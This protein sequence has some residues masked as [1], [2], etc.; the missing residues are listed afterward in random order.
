MQNSPFQPFGPTVTIT[1]GGPIQVTTNNNQS[2]T[3]YRIRNVTTADSYIFWAAPIASGG[4][5]AITA[6]APA[7]GS[8][9]ANCIGLAGKVVEKVTL[10]SNAW[11]VN[12]ANATLEVTPGEGL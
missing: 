3:A 5:P 2:A 10:P 8:P 12:G 11:F 9:V 4:T 1:G 6:T 7:F